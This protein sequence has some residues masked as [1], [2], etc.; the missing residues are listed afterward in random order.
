MPTGSGSA[1]WVVVTVKP[2]NVVNFES[3]FKYSIRKIGNRNF[4]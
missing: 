2:G 3:A 1:G 4:S